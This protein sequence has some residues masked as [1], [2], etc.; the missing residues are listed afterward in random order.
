MISEYIH[1]K[2][3]V[4]S[5][6]DKI[7]KLQYILSYL[8]SHNKNLTKTQDWL[9]DDALDLIKD[10]SFCNLFKFVGEF[11]AEIYQ[12]LHDKGIDT[13]DLDKATSQLYNVLNHIENTFKELRP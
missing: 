10:K 2:N 3:N 12:T 1:I 4:D 11:L 5:L 9:I 8:Q 6:N 7:E 13:K